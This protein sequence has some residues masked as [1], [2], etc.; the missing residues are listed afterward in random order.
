ESV[1]ISLL[2]IDE[3]HCISQ[4]GHDFRPHYRGLSAHLRRLPEA[5]IL[6]VTA[7]ATPQVEQDIV[8]TLAPGAMHV[9]HACFD[10]PNLHF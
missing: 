8:N 1:D 2:V 3:A 9:V 7:T 5:V 10:R 6:A 4:W